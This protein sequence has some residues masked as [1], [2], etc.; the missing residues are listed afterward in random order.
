[1]RI[2]FIGFFDT[3]RGYTLHFTITHTHTHT[4]TNV[5]SH[6]FTSRCS[7]AAY[8]GGRFPSTG[9]PNSLRPQVPASNS[10]SSRLNLSGS[11]TYSVTHEPTNSIQLAQLHYHDY[12]YNISA[13]TAQETPLLCCCIQLLPWKYACLQSRYLLMA[14]VLFLISR[15]FPSNASI[16]H[17]IF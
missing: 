1:L 3:A 5:H 15:P 9:L 4:H 13:R 17:N 12:V 6:V 8:K 16:C 2:G 10:N 7:V 11:L 14:V